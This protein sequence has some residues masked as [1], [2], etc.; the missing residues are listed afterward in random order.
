[1]VPDVDAGE[2]LAEVTRL[3][4]MLGADP[5]D[6]PGITDGFRRVR[7]A[8]DKASGVRSR[9][10]DDAVSPLTRLARVT[11]EHR[12]LGDRMNA[13]NRAF[14]AAQ[15]APATTRAIGDTS[16]AT[17]AVRDALA[18]AARAKT[19][20]ERNAAINAANRAFWDGRRA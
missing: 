15:A 11:P 3:N 4:A 18:V 9:T 10:T 1:L 2:V 12:A 13:A 17:T 8:A 6:F 16:P 14:W 20:I 19:D 5:Q 7:Q